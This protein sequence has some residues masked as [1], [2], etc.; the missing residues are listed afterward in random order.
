MAVST[1]TTDT[2]TDAAEPA[3]DVGTRLRALHRRGDLEAARQLIDAM[4]ELEFTDDPEVR[5]LLAL[6][7]FL[8]DDHAGAARYLNG[9]EA[10]GIASADGWSDFGLLCFISGDAG[11]A[12]R[13]LRHAIAEGADDS[14]VYTRLGAVV[15]RK[16]E[17]EEAQRLFAQSLEREPERAEV[18]NNLGGIAVRQGDLTT[19]LGYYERA[20]DKRPDLTPAQQQRMHVLTQLDSLD[21][22][23]DE[24]RAKVTAEPD[25]P[26]HHLRLARVLTQAERTQE[27]EATLDGAVRRFPD[28]ADVKLAH[29]EHLFERKR[30]W[31]A[32]LALQDYVEQHPESMA[33]RRMLNEAR[34]EA[35][36]LDTVEADLDTL[37]PQWAE[38]PAFL[39]Q[40]ARLLTERNRHDEAV[41]LLRDVI[42]RYPGVFPAYNRL[43]HALNQLGRREEA[44]SYLRMIADA[45]PAA[46][47]QA[48]ADDP[49]SATAQQE[50][51]LRQMKDAVNQPRNSRASAAFTL[52]NVY[53]KQKRYDEAFPVLSEANELARAD[54]NY[55][56]RRHRRTTQRI[57]DTFTADLVARLYADGG[58]ESHA[59]IFIVGMPR[60]GTTLVE[61]I[62]CSHPEV[63][64]GG[65]LQWVPRVTRLMPSVLR[66]HGQPSVAFP[67]AM[68]YANRSLLQAAGNYY[69]ERATAGMD[70]DTRFI[71]DKLPHN[72]DNVGLIALMFPN[73]SIIHLD[74]EPRDVA[75][76][77]FF[78][79]YAAAQGLMGFAYD[80]EDIGHM[81]N[82]HERIMAHWHDLLPGRVYDLSYERLVADPETTIRDVLAF[83]GLPWDERVM[84]FY[85][86]QR[87][88]RTAS[89]RQVREGIHQGS[90]AK[91]R[92]YADFL[93]PLESVL[94][95]GYEPLDEDADDDEGASGA[96]GWSGVIAGPTG[97]A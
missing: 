16:G 41:P 44:E 80:L 89:I 87:P 19:A 40:R 1:E 84:R 62:L 53:D 65:E 73:A 76:S 7:A 31:R 38:M 22:L 47:Q 4:P 58:H 85:E 83:C 10:D 81:L 52:A 43:A 11:A 59:P 20:L 82:D 36:F 13:C 8:R 94:A 54:L 77:N 61:Q 15:M 24:Q 39:M 48:I 93:E 91:W 45:N 96:E 33:L 56:W 3:A 2:A 34:L 97:N 26:G 5:V 42:D 23:V 28:D 51:R 60:S 71:T 68:A 74:R 79:N 50:E 46:F 9:L 30:W 17:L 72:F 37:D 78:Q 25:T 27:A 21:V 66:D 32:G 49:G 86:T 14:A 88:V 63:H 18:L 6:T 29:A 57:I 75:V 70:P 35:G 67:D 95:H 92:R 90:A 12:E 69:L 55:D 64:G